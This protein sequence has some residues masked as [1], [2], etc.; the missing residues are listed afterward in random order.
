M[1]DIIISIRTRW[2]MLL[3]LVFISN[4][5]RD[6]FFELTNPPEFPW[7]NVSELERGAVSPYNIAFSNSWG[8]F[9]GD[10][11]LVSECMSDLVYLLPNT[12]ADIP[13]NEMYFRTTDTEISKANGIFSSSYKAIGACNSVIDFLDNFN[14]SPYPDPTPEDVLNIR[15]IKGE[16]YF[17]RAY[18]YFHLVRIHAP[19]PSNPLFKTEDILPLRLTFPTS[20]TEANEPEYATAELIYQVIF[21]DL[22]AA[23]ELL[24]EKYEPSVHHPSYQHG[25]A[26]RYA[27]SALLGRAYFMIGNLDLALPELD[28][29]L[30][31]PFTLDQN[32]IE[33]FNRSDA[34]SGEEVIWYALYY[35]ITKGSTQK[36]ATSFNYSDYRA[37]NGG[38]GENHRRCTWHQ[39]TLSHALLKQIGWMDN[40]LN[41]TDEALNDKRYQQLYW[42]LEPYRGDDNDDPRYYDLQ[43]KHIKTP[44][45][46]GDKY[47]RGMDGQFSN[48]PVIRLA[49][50][51]LTRSII[52]LKKG[53]QAGALEDLNIVRSRAG[54]SQLSVVSEQDIHNE[55][56]KEL[57]FEGDRLYYLQALNLPIPPGDR[58]DTAPV[59][60]PYDNLYWRLPQSELDFR[61]D[62]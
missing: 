54:L 24:P 42:R 21:D 2:M 18:S 23:K 60:P 33:A 36:V 27:A 52:H 38:R 5:C 41:V 11:Q 48:V 46:Y 53:N 15:R 28:Y 56:I 44:Q 3:V 37:I 1:K 61:T 13:F 43:Y 47:F 32:P 19:A 31:G 20:Y 17:M 49:E 45:V 40:N 51:Y 34:T 30:S 10:T 39:F 6:D 35:D 57:A 50:M 26:T 59:P 4:A 25:R 55:R 14:D 22:I 16:A 29:V 58:T 8:N 12:S 7:L 9:F 62:Q